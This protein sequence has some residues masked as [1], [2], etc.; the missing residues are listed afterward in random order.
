MYWLRLIGGSAA[1]IALAAVVFFFAD[2][3]TRGWFDEEGAS[4]MVLAC[5]TLAALAGGAL[6]A[7]IGAGIPANV[8]AAVMALLALVNPTEG[9][10]LWWYLPSAIVLVFGA[11]FVGSKL[12]PRPDFGHS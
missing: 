7:A 6:A 8:M 1:G 9:D 5:Y 2:W 10:D 4:I 12:V 11:A 3:I